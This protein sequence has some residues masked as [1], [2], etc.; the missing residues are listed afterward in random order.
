VYKAKISWRKL[1]CGFSLFV[2]Y[3]YGEQRSM[4]KGEVGC[5]HGAE[6]YA[7]F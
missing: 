5:K 7:E 3:S 1:L 2:T 4:K 6:L